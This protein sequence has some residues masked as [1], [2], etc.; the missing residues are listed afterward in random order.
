M[1]YFLY[2]ASSFAATNVLFC[3]L[4]RLKPVNFINVATSVQITETNLRN[5]GRYF[6]FKNSSQFYI[7]YRL[8]RNPLLKAT[9]NH[10]T[11][12]EIPFISSSEVVNVA[13]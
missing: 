10:I 9:N 2:Y 5:S 3:T 12:T 11:K 13:K 8:T 6:I 1:T 7:S 4:D